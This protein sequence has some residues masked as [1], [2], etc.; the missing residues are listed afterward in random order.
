MQLV[1]DITRCVKNDIAR[2]IIGSRLFGIGRTTMALAQLSVLV[3][4]DPSYYFLTVGENNINDSCADALIPISLYCFSPGNSHIA[5]Y[6]AV[7]ILVVVA[8]GI[9]PRY[10]AVLHFWVSFSIAST[11]SLPD[12]GESV[13]QVMTLFMMI[14]CLGDNRLW[15]WQSPRDKQP[16]GL[17]L[18]VSWA[19]S[20]FVRIQIAYVYLNSGLA[21]L[22]VEQWQEGTATYY[23]SRME[24]FGA[25]GLFDDQFKALLSVP[26]FALAS[27]WGTIAVEVLLA[28]FIVSNS[29][30]LS[31]FAILLSALMHVMIALMIGIVSFAV[32]MTSSVIVACS[33]SIC[34]KRSVSENFSLTSP[35]NDDEDTGRTN[36]NARA[37]PERS[38]YTLTGK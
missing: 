10:T 30:R 32:I 23:V 4:T 20:W 27:T 5:N 37:T 34:K 21:K 15:H 3:L 12:G 6:I 11:I 17:L 25:A 13:M 18:G 2:T 7:A 14:A 28:L 36:S 29:S 16:S 35:T 22:A 8:S 26:V 9:L 33:Y 19:G 38:G 1:R 31:K 24:Y